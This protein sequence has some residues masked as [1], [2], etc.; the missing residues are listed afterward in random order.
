MTAAAPGCDSQRAAEPKET[1][2][3]D[4]ETNMVLTLGL[5]R[6]AL[7][8]CKLVQVGATPVAAGGN[9]LVSCM[10]RNL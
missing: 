1:P 6:S 10:A 4:S 8:K 3:R 7:K 2:R 5:L 9:C